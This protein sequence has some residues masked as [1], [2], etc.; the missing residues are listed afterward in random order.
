VDAN[1]T[2]I[3]P[4]CQ[5]CSFDFAVTQAMKC[6]A[7]VPGRDLVLGVC[8]CP[9]ATYSSGTECLPCGTGCQQCTGPTSCTLCTSNSAPVNGVCTCSAGFFL[10]PAT[11]TCQPCSSNCLTCSSSSTT[12]LSCRPPLTLSSSQCVCPP[13]T[14]TNDGVQCTS[15]TA[16]CQTCTNRLLC[17]VCNAG[18]KL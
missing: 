4:N 2:R 6:D 12:C 5:D 11:Q 13:G 3:D 15:C 9:A 16:N 10:A 17:S 14:F 18:F 1:C 7:C 8:Q